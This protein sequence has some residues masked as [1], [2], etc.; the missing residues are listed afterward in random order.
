MATLTI[1]AGQ[2][3][4]LDAAASPGGVGDFTFASGDPTKVLIERSFGD[5]C[6]LRGVAAGASTVTVSRGGASATVDVT[7][8][9]GTACTLVDL[10]VPEKL[11]VGEEGVAEA[12]AWVGSAEDLARYPDGGAVELASANEAVAAVVA[13]LDARR[14]RVRG[15]GV[16]AAVL[17]A[18]H[19]GGEEKE[20]VV[21]VIA[22][23]ADGAVVVTAR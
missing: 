2:S 8:L 17:T 19:E 14:W 21:T 11:R 12:Q 13:R 22:A 3:A 10:V 1:K 6:I 9:G 7:V 18:T 5:R 16:G 15:V 20:R 23:A 4:P